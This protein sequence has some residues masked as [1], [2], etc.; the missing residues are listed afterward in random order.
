MG[1]WL[2]VSCWFDPPIE[3]LD[4][5]NPNVIQGKKG[6]K[7]IR[8]CVDLR[9]LNFSCVHNPF[10]TPYSDEIL[11]AINETYSFKDGL[12]GY[13]QVCNT[14]EDTNNTTFT[15][16]SGR[17]YYCWEQCKWRHLH[18]INQGED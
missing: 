9:I 12:Y 18:Y 11:D 8:V 1:N 3:K 6:T 10:T 2:N 16:V 5:I 15:I 7:K 4:W 17:T 14:Q 13:H